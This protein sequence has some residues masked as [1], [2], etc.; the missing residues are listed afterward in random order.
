MNCEAIISVADVLGKTLHTRE[1]A[2]QLLQK[3][4]EH[5]CSTIELDFL[6]VD[7][8]SRSFADQF[9]SDKLEL[10]AVSEK[11]IVVVNANEEVVRMLQA[12]AR[13]Q[14]KA[15]QS[16]GLPVFKYSNWNHLENFLLS[17]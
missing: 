17:I 14:N 9:H 1:A 5:P 2:V 6:G 13:T 10:A 4:A 3:V 12:V 15:Y 16:G 7:Y 8:M 11:T